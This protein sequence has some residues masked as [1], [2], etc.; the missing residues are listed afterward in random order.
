[1]FDW[2]VMAVRFCLRRKPCEASS[3]VTVMRLNDI[4]AERLVTVWPP[5]SDAFVDGLIMCTINGGH[6][7]AL[8]GGQE[9]SEETVLV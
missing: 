3:L 5:P 7:G 2:S 9:G 6:L 1:M 8:Y 4:K